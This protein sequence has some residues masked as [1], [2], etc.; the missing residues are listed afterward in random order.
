MEKLVELFYQCSGISTDTRKIEKDCLFICL[1]GENFNGNTFASK[2]LELGAKY[3]ISDDK[4]Y[5]TTD[6][7]FYVENSLIF[8]QKLANFHRLKFN[9]PFIGITGSNG[10]TS[11]KELINTVLSKKYKVLATEG[12]LNNHIGVPLTLLKLKE[13]HEIAIIEMGAN[14]FKDIE[15]LC[16]IAKPTHGIITNIGKAH[17]EGFKNFDGVLRTKKE[18][19]DSISLNQGTIFYNEDDAILKNILPENINTLSYGTTSD[20]EIQG[21]L[22]SLTPFV[23]MKWKIKDYQSE[24]IETSMI[25]KYNFYNFLAAIS[26]GVYF[27]VENVAISQA[28]SEYQPTNNR[29]QV[30]KTDKNTLILDAYN[31]NPT[32]MRS[33]IESFALIENPNKIAILGDMFELGTESISEHKNIV[34]LIQKLKIKSS[35]IGERFYENQNLENELITFYKTKDDFKSFKTNQSVENQLILLKGSRGI[36]LENLV[37]LF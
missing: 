23:K 3:V 36:G 24:E 26:F 33:A 10:K 12:N 30:K 37:E 13:E 16:E 8:L 4:T 9:I 34:E 20:S 27:K 2:A 22:C 18:L 14:K 35:F 11:T 6:S 21:E 15:E 31:A 17:L 7:I 29:S 5:C 32:S 25:G 1:S 28:I 19:Y